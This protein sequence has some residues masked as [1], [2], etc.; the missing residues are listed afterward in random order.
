MNNPKSFGGVLPPVNLKRKPPFPYHLAHILAA[1]S[2]EQSVF[3]ISIDIVK[4]IGKGS[5]NRIAMFRINWIE[6]NAI[7]VML[8]QKRAQ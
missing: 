5:R 8:T 7:P 4:V 3:Q 6:D 1:T 2:M